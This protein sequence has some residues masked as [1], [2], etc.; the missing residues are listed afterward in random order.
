MSSTFVT[1]RHIRFQ[2]KHWFTTTAIAGRQHVHNSLTTTY[3][4]SLIYGLGCYFIVMARFDRPQNETTSYFERTRNW[5]P[6]Q[7]VLSTSTLGRCARHSVLLPDARLPSLLETH[8]Q[9]RWHRLTWRPRTVGR[10]S[11]AAVGLSTWCL[12]RQSAESW[13]R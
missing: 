4:S 7:P 1:S 3:E 10:L 6:R 9:Q 13:W 2:E 8:I 5:L 11:T 12:L